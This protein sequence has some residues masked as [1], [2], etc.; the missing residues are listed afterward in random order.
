MMS[1][2]DADLAR[3][4]ILDVAAGASSFTAGARARGFEASAVDPLYSLTLAEMRG[5]GQDEI[6]LSTEKLS[7]IAHTFQWDYY[8]TINH[9]R[10]NREVSLACFLADYALDSGRDCYRVGCLPHLPFPDEQFS[11]VLSSHFLF[12]Y[13]EQFP[14]SFHIRSIREL[15]RVLR[16]GGEIRLYPLVVLNRDPYPHLDQLCG[17]LLADGLCIELLPTA[18]RFLEGAT[19][20]LSIK[21]VE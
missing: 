1:L 19:E 17:D 9:H 6:A 11:L 8:K 5:H 18:F 10:E 16:K 15:V 12:L 13:H 2:A 20:I 7:R 21:K 3:G 14:Y 4:P